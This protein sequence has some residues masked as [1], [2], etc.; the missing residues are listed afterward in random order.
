[1]AASTNQSNNQT[2]RFVSSSSS[3]R[4][5]SSLT[6]EQS[7][8]SL[9][10]LQL[11]K[12]EGIEFDVAY[13][14][15]LKR[16]IKTLYLIQEELDCHWLPVHKSWRLNERHHGALQGLSKSEMAEKYGEDKVKVN[17]N[18][19]LARWPWHLLWQ[20]NLPC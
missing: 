19:P 7:N 2:I 5:V 10:I 14:S 6:I 8:N 16:A 9:C 18:K 20:M 15:V 4:R 13:T 3:R 17:K 12:K 11:I 1:M